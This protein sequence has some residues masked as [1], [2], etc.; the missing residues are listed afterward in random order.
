MSELAEL[1]EQLNRIESRLIKAM[2]GLSSK[3]LTVAEFAANTRRSVKFIRARIAAR[4][5]RT[6]PGGKPFLIPASELAKFI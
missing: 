1:A 4:Q 3:P 5:I 6:L 2:E